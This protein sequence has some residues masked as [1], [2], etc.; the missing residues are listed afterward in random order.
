VG[1]AIVPF[2]ILP[3]HDV[4]SQW[5]CCDVVLSDGNTVVV[6]ARLGGGLGF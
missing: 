6:A 1:H 2:S 3:Y 5:R 4:L